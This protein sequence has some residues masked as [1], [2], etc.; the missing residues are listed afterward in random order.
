[1]MIIIMLIHDDDDD[2][3]EEEVKEKT[4]QDSKYL[5]DNYLTMQC[6]WVKEAVYHD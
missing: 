5:Y 6:F 3:E 2:E 4:S 1:M